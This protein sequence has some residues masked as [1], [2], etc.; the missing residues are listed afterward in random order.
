MLLF[1]VSIIFIALAY[2]AYVILS[3]RPTD[4]QVAMHYSAFGETHYYRNKW[5]YL[6]SFV[7]FGLVVVSLHLAILFKLIREDFRSLA[8]G[9]AWLTII[10]LGLACIFAHSV[11]SIAFLS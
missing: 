2:M 5:Y 6:L 11:L 1:C 10:L 9:F 3:L 4:V 8:V 7:A